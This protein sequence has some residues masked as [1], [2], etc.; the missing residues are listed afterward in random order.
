MAQPKQEKKE[1]EPRPIDAVP[2][3]WDTMCD[4]SKQMLKDTS[5]VCQIRRSKNDNRV[6]YQANLIDDPSGSGG[7][8]LNPQEPIKV[9]WLK[10]E[11][12]Y[13]AKHRKS[14]KKDDR[15]ELT[16]LE[17]N[18]AYGISW[19]V[20]GDAKK[21]EYKITFVALKERPAILKI[22]PKDNL[23]KCFGKVQGKDGKQVE[24]IL[25]DMYVHT[26]ENW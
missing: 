2:P 16:F 9:F 8:I 15:T 17:S 11:P 26:T 22:D 4:E 10:I 6:V 13:I 19:E 18:M 20:H 14:G 23:P 12:S 25:T 1:D 3:G 5:V 21:R 7:K 24:A